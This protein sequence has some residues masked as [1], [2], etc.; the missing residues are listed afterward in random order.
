[1]SKTGGSGGGTIRF[2]EELAHGG[3]ADLLEPVHEAHK[4]VSYADLYTLAGVVAIEAANGEAAEQPMGLKSSRLNT[5]HR[6][7]QGTRRPCR[8]KS[9]VEGWAGRR[10]HAGC[11][12]S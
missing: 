12:Y 7:L 6:S 8:P 10:P 9:G 11:G 3:N 2:K 4:G 1:M 5:L